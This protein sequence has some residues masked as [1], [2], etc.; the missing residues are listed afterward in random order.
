MSD[1]QILKIQP[2]D[3]NTLLEIATIDQES[4]GKDGLTPANLSLMARAGKDPL[5]PPKPLF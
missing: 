1:F 2:D 5:F 3:W 4:F